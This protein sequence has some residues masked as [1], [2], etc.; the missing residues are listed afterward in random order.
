M[1]SWISCRESG[2]C[3]YQ[4]YYFLL[5]ASLP[6]SLKHDLLS[7]RCLFLCSFCLLLFCDRYERVPCLEDNWNNLNKPSP[8]G[9]R[10]VAGVFI[11]LGCGLF[12]GI[13]ILMFEH[14]FYKYLLPKIR[15]KPK[16]CF[17]KSPNL[18]FFSQVCILISS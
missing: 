9:I 7:I 1:V 10:S 15:I 12:A 17:W 14:L 4:S 5:L 11:M 18:M 2:E 13:L 16:D 6:V 3:R 8:L